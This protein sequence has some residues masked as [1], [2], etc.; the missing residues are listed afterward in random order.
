MWVPVLK[1]RVFSS[2]WVMIAPILAGTCLS[3]SALKAEEVGVTLRPIRDRGG[4]E[5]GLNIRLTQAFEKFLKEHS[6]FPFRVEV[7]EKRVN[8]TS[9][10]HSQYV[11]TGEISFS[12][13]QSEAQGRYLLTVRLFRGDKTR[14]I[15]GQWAGTADS[16][17]YLTANLRNAPHVHTYGLI[18]EMGSRVISALKTDLSHP[19]RRW[20]FSL[21]SVPFGKAPEIEESSAKGQGH[22]FSGI[23]EGV[24]FCV[25]L[26]HSATG[27]TFLLSF[28]KAGNSAVVALVVQPEPNKGNL[29]QPFSLSSE[30][31]EAWILQE[32]VVT[33]AHKSRLFLCKR[34]QSAFSE[35]ESPV[36]VLEGMGHATAQ[37]L[38]TAQ[39]LLLTQIGL[40]HENWRKFRLR[41]SRK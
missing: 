37:P 4:I 26:P 3:V 30:T 31:S 28:D 36:S 10:P 21:S 1:V 17:R 41:L 9:F 40:H 32:A 19:E 33:S 14:R 8:D 15:I 20:L 22:P 29:S 12:N 7:S 11:L 38:Q 25:R 24:P 18:G 39:E 2:L 23:T 6:T 5:R 13:G 16:F 27:R 35:D 34:S